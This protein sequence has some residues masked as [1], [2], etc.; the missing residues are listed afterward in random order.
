ME[1]KASRWKRKKN[2][3][4]IILQPRDRDILQTVYAF[5]VLSREQLQQLLGIDGTRRI[6]QRLRKLYDHKYL[7]RYFL[8][9][10]RGRA[11]AIYYLGPRGAEL[12]ADDLGV[13]LNIPTCAASYVRGKQTSTPMT[14]WSQYVPGITNRCCQRLM[15]SF[16]SLIRACACASNSTRCSSGI[17]TIY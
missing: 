7:S 1:N 6:N 8:H 14:I 15:R 12:V 10:N 17:V 4:R 3:G 9:N 11:K 5:R 16:A 2:P 13:D